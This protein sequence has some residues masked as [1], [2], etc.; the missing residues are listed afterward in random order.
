VQMGTLHKDEYQNYILMVL[1]ETQV[2]AG[3]F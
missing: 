1:K 3:M 2:T